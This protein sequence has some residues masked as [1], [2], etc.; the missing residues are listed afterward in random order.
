VSETAAD[1]NIVILHHLK[2]VVSPE[3]FNNWFKDLVVIGRSG[4]K[5]QLGAPSRYHKN[6]IEDHYAKDLLRI[7]RDVDKE[8]DSVEILYVSA[9]RNKAA[10]SSTMSAVLAKTLPEHVRATPQ[11]IPAN[12]TSRPLPGGF[13]HTPLSTRLRLEWFVAGKSNRV[14]HAARRRT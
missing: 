5:L 7:A 1:T 6:W 3:C 12:A 10:D 11:P 2:S 14:A 8:I 9:F 4:T 13:T